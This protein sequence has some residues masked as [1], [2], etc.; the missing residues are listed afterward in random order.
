MWTGRCE[1]A[2]LDMPAQTFQSMSNLN[3]WFLT[4]CVPSSWVPFGMSLLR[5]V[6]QFQIFS[7]LL[8][9]KLRTDCRWAVEGGTGNNT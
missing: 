5:E 1:G 7:V 8:N 9:G 2:T 4:M 6:A 3:S